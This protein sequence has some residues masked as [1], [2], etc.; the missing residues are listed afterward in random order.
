MSPSPHERIPEV[1]RD[2]LRGAKRSI[3]IRILIVACCPFLFAAQ[4]RADEVVAIA[5][6]ASKDY[7][8]RKLPD[9][10]FRP[11]S[12]VFGKG[13]NLGGARVDPTID[14]MEFMDVARTI[15]VPLAEKRYLPTANPKT[16]NLLIMVYWGTTRA[17]EYATESISHDLMQRATEQEDNAKIARIAASQATSSRSDKMIAAAEAAGADDALIAATIGVQAED[18]RREDTDMRNA[19]LLGYDSW[20]IATNSAMDGSPLGRRKADMK[21]ELEEDR[22][23]VVLSA[24]DY[25][26]LVKGKKMKFLWEVRFS[27]REHGNAFDTKLAGMVAKASAY[28]GRD[29]G[30]LQ[31][32]DIPDGKV[33]LGE[34]RSL[35]VVSAND[36]PKSGN[37]TVSPD[38]SK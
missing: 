24:F 11:E 38:P 30:G 16:T 22:Y 37:P 33:E 25:Q 14:K 32:Q 34:I 26:A 18:Q 15:A 6:K 7:V 23:F 35:G 27:I 8:R 9:G 2:S 13:D 5:S 19:T 28:F 17:S 29:S 10:T 36:A 4:A 12:Y 31:H 3:L 20:W 1:G 21:A